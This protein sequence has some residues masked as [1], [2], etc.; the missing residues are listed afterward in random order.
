[1]KQML[2]DLA[3][4]GFMFFILACGAGLVEFINQ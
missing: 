2:E 1:M 3:L 4:V